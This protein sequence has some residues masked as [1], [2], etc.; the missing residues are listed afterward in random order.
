LQSSGVST[1][2]NVYAQPITLLNPSGDVIQ[3]QPCRIKV[4]N[5]EPATDEA[6]FRKLLADAGVLIFP[7]T[8]GRTRA[9]EFLVEYFTP[10]D[11]INAVYTIQE[12]NE[13]R[14]VNERVYGAEYC[15]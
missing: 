15:G 13:K 7:K 10:L 11:A 2:Y 12:Y 3:P 1:T 6:G 14:L 8:V 5:V 4:T 9:G